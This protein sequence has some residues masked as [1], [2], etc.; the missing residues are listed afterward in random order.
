MMPFSMPSKPIT[1]SIM[2]FMLTCA[3]GWDEVDRG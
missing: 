3:A 2:P 1:I